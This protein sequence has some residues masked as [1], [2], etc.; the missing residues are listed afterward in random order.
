MSTFNQNGAIQDVI[1]NETIDDQYDVNPTLDL[2]GTTGDDYMTGSIFSSRTSVFNHHN[3]TYSESELNSPFNLTTYVTYLTPRREVMQES[4]RN[5]TVIDESERIYDSMLPALDE[6]VL[7]NGGKGIALIDGIISASYNKTLNDFQKESSKT[8]LKHATFFLDAYEGWRYTMA[9]SSLNP[10]TPSVAK[11]FDAKY[12]MMLNYSDRKWT[13]GFPFSPDYSTLLRYNNPI[14]KID[15]EVGFTNHYTGS[16]PITKVNNGFADVS[17]TNNFTYVP[18]RLAWPIS[19][20]QDDISKGVNPLSGTLTDTNGIAFTMDTSISDG[21][22]MSTNPEQMDQITFFT[23]SDSDLIKIFYGFG[24]KNT[25][26]FNPSG[27]TNFVDFGHDLAISAAG[28]TSPLLR[29]TIPTGSNFDDSKSSEYKFLLNLP[30]KPI[31]RG[32]KYGIYNGLPT[33]TKAVWRRD[34]YG[35]FRDM[36]EQRTFTKNYIYINNETKKGKQD[37]VSDPAVK[38]TFV[39]LVGDVIPP[40][41]SSRSSNISIEA[42]SSLPYTADEPTNR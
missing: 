17:I 39:N 5:M 37:H 16:T 40:L 30:M 31:I 22:L 32:W 3:T 6:I 18:I 34:R 11:W 24:D 41:S 27:S 14:K 8:V 26:S 15:P 12:N 20:S 23:P 21:M 13:K 33:Y 2:V 38:V 7:K 42:T 36:L 28:G 9:S 19:G 35:Q 10:I 25:K 4:N 1:G 29:T